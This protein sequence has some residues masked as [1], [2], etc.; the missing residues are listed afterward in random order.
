M[1]SPGVID[2]SDVVLII[3]NVDGADEI[4]DWSENSRFVFT[5]VVAEC[6]WRG[7]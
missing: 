2:Y 6:S 7:N 3:G 1:T 5:P 4:L